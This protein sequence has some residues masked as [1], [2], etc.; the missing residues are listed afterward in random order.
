MRA[1][2]RTAWRWF[3]RIKPRP[4]W[5][6]FPSVG[7]GAPVPRPKCAFTRWASRPSV[8][9]LPSTQRSFVTKLGKIGLHFHALAR[10]EDPRPVQGRRSFKSIGSEHTLET[11]VSQKADLK[12]HLRRS[13]EAVGRRLRQKRY[14]AYGIGVK[15]KTTQFRILTRQHRL[16][17]P[18]DVTERLYSV[19]VELL[20]EFNDPGPFRLVASIIGSS[21]IFSAPTP[22]NAAWSWPSI[23]LPRASALTS[24]TA[25]MT[26]P[27]LPGCVW[28]RLLTVRT[29]SSWTRAERLARAVGLRR[30]IPQS[31][32]FSRPRRQ[33]REAGSRAPARRDRCA[34]Q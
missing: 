5:H 19:A 30:Q 25:P 20:D 6:R 24:C 29:I 2:S 33:T 26:S 9:W 14:V 15:L 4:G 16:S 27:R 21:S 23:A 31:R 11:D 32:L 7:C 13:A 28:H 1:E 10:A 17:E 18:T 34:R 22:G 8:T 3:R 12:L